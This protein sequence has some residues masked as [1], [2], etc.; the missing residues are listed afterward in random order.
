MRQ[1]QERATTKT[2]QKKKIEN[3]N[4]RRYYKISSLKIC[5]LAF[6][7]FLSTRVSEKEINKNNIILPFNYCVFIFGAIVYLILSILYLFYILIIMEF[8]SLVVVVVK[9][10]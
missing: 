9:Y 4:H 2:N 3:K 1:Q 5:A 6:I 7:L 8:Q 10:A